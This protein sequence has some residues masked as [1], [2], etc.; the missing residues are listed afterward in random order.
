MDRSVEL[1]R[2]EQ[3][4][5]VVGVGEI[6]VEFEDIAGA[7]KGRQALGGRKF[8]GKAVKATFF[9]HDL[10]KASKEDGC[11]GMPQENKSSVF[12]ELFLLEKCVTRDFRYW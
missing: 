8:S 2:P 10:F 4:K 1:P 11:H 3:G 5:E 6:F 12:L 7:S 9:P